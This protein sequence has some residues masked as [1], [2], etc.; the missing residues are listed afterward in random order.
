M[1]SIHK[2][3]LIWLIRFGK[4]KARIVHFLLLCTV[5]FAF[6]TGLDFI[7]SI[8]TGTPFS[9]EWGSNLPFCFF[10][11]VCAPFISWRFY[12]V[13]IIQ[14]KNYRQLEKKGLTPEDLRRIAFVKKWDMVRRSGIARYCFFDG[15]V[16][17]GMIL[18]F[19]ISFVMLQTIKHSDRLFDDLNEMIAFIGKN[20]ILGYIIG[21][22][23]YRFRWF[24][25]ERRFIRL[26]NPL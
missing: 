23:I 24:L 9:D 12:D 26:T 1:T 13:T 6:I 5:Y 18:L 16:I 3:F 4:T 15:G 11:F 10:F 2:K 21:L 25:N 14:L 8:V 7:L 20:I 22:L 17:A 19:P